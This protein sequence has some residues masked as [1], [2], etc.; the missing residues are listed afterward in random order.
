MS[1]PQKTAEELGAIIAKRMGDGVRVI[2]NP[3]G[4]GGWHPTVLKVGADLLRLDEY[5]RRANKIATE[6]RVKLSMKD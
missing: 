4:A 1:K 6:L 2:V 3:D 5:Q